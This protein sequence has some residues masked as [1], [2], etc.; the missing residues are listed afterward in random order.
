MLDKS[1]TTAYIGY[2]EA[3]NQIKQ[4]LNQPAAL[5][6]IA[7]RLGQ[8]DIPH[9]TALARQ[10]C[11]QFTFHDGRGRAQV[12][13]CLRALREL[14]RAGHFTLPKACTTPGVG[15]IRRLSAP[16]APA[17]DVPERAGDVRDLRLVRVDTDEHRRIWNELMLCEHPQGA[18][19]L[20]G[21]QL[22]YLIDSAHGW[23][24]GFGFS[25]AALQL[26][27][28]DDWIGWDSATRRE[29][30]HRVISMSRFLLR[31]PGCHNLASQVLG[32]VLRRIADDVESQY[33]Y[34]PWLVE[35]FVD[36]EAFDGTCYRA[37]NWICV[38]QTQGRGRQDRTHAA[39]KGVKAIYLYPLVQHWR[40]R[41]GVAP[42]P[43]PSTLAVGE[44]LDSANWVEQEFGD[45]PLGD[46]RLSKRLVESAR[47]QAAQ[48][49]RAFTG[50]A[51]GD[52]PATKGYYR[53]IDQPPESAVTMAAIL[54][55]HQARTQQRMQ[56][57]ARVLCI[58]DGTTLDYTGL[59]QCSGLGVTGSNQTGA[60]SRG[61][62][63]HSTLAI[64][65]EG[66]PLGIVDARCRAPDPEAEKTTPKT[67]IEEKKSFDW[68][69]GLRACTALAEQMP[70]TRITSVMDREA[71]FFELF[72]E[73]RNHP[74]V[75]VLVRA[76]YNR[77]LDKETKLFDHLRA[78]EARGEV[79]LTVK[80][81]SA[82]G[83]RSKQKAQTGR[84]QREATLTLHYEQVELPPGHYH[85]DKAPVGVSAV[86]A[87]EAAPPEGVAPVEWFLLTSRS[88]GSVDDARQCLQDYAL[89]WRIEDW[90]R[91]LKSGCEIEE[92]AHQSVE[93]LERAITINLVIAWHIMV[94]TLLGREVPEL[95]AEVLFSE[96]EIEVLQAY[97]NAN[98]L[99]PPTNLGETVRLVARLGGYL[100]RKH[101]PPP[102]HQLIW[103]GYHDLTNM[104][105]GYALLRPT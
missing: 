6:W 74:C 7:D 21:A 48:P 87:V 56:A 10:V 42:P 31:E 70:Q 75:D 54:Q 18:G 66:I 43:A 52:W 40:S 69:A 58:Q 77:R 97:S 28:R 61:L 96:L 9:R 85:A 47:R 80:R 72:D 65:G 37:S 27:D 95:P 90:H 50:V 3:Q 20:V 33:G 91:V 8:G 39:D 81:R 63:L 86:H 99:K 11:E 102:G 36:L 49:G 82:R 60:Q 13:G 34:R 103:Q 94:M 76:K 83:K 41:L 44:G 32:Q 15:G 71:D 57:Q 5:A 35:S 30:L 68:V 45:A 26:R 73:Q 12:S 53:L 17:C 84:Q 59:E 29:Q 2:V 105:A 104:C 98:G 22:R 38:G 1:H 46:R 51:K 101:D 25:A 67:P 89:R 79:Q 100:G 16:V 23:L 14:E 88:I 24:G 55:P 78:S 93:R 19:P 4:T 64:S 62:H 92:L